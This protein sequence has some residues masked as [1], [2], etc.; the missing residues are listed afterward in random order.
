MWRVPRKCT[1][2]AK[3]TS[4]YTVRA[5]MHTGRAPD[6]AHQSHMGKLEKEITGMKATDDSQE[7]LL[8]KR[9]LEEE[10]D[11]GVPGIVRKYWQEFPE[12]A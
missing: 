9:C 5:G 1:C 12:D 7:E 8:R 10:Q 11:R 4:G 3:G 6:T 2:E